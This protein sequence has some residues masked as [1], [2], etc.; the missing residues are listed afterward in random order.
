MLICG[1]NKGLKVRLKSS[2]ESLLHLQRMNVKT[3]FR[4]QTIHSHISTQWRPNSHT[5]F[6][7]GCEYFGVFK[8]SMCWELF[9]SLWS[10]CHAVAHRSVFNSFRPQWEWGMLCEGFSAEMMLENRCWFWSF[11]WICYYTHNYPLSFEGT[12]SPLLTQLQ[13]RTMLCCAP[14]SRVNPIM[15]HSRFILI[16]AHTL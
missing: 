5:Q 13:S 4:C 14:I 8:F 1:I 7:T 12:Y 2:T 10:L 9:S 16:C 6:S 3:T 11:H 15:C